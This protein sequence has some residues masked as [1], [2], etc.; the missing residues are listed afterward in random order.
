MLHTYAPRTV[1]ITSVDRDI[2]KQLHVFYH[3]EKIRSCKLRPQIDVIHKTPNNE[4]LSDLKW[5]ESVSQ[6]F[7]TIGLDVAD[8][9][10]YPLHPVTMAYHY[11]KAYPRQTLC[12]EIRRDLIV[13]RWEPFSEMRISQEKAEKLAACLARSLD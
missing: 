11:A 5:Y 3:S 4:E 2:V 12:I 9:A 1:P 13:E 8:G 7:R 10:S 6:E